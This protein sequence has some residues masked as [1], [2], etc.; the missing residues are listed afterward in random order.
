[1]ANDFEVMNEV[2]EDW[3]D[4]AHKPARVCVEANMAK[5]NILFEVKGKETL[6]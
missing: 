4:A 2:W 5:P 1:M 3:V 6:A